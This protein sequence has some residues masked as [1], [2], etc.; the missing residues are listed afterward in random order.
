MCQFPVFFS[1]GQQRPLFFSR[2]DGVRLCDHPWGSEDSD[3]LPEA[4]PAPGGTGPGPG[5]R[6][7]QPSLLLVYWRDHRPICGQLQPGA[8]AKKLLHREMAHW[9]DG[10]LLVG[11]LCSQAP[12]TPGQISPLGPQAPVGWWVYPRV[13]ALSPHLLIRCLVLVLQQLE[14]IEPS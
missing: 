3:R 6:P 11:V 14:L 12:C 13:D 4:L 10:P 2:S 5:R 1:K 8:A 7:Q 9:Q